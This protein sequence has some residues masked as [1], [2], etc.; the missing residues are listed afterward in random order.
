MTEYTRWRRLS[1][2][3][4]SAEMVY[5]AEVRKCRPPRASLVRSTSGG[6][7]MRIELRRGGETLH[8]SGEVG[9]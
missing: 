1:N 4:S 2:G 3:G 5:F 6:S 9:Q 8:A 7:I